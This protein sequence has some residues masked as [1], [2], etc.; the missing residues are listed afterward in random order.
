MKLS[1]VNSS[2]AIH[3]LAGGTS[4]RMGE[5]KSLLRLRGMTLLDW[6]RIT[7]EALGHPVQVI[8][9][10][11]QPGKG[12]LAGIETGLNQSDAMVQLFLSCDMPLVSVPTLFD[13][14]KAGEDSDGVACMEVNERRG[15]P[16]V[17]P[18]RL[19]PFIQSELQAD[20]R[21]L[22][23]LFHHS[24]CKVFR[25][26]TADHMESFNINTPEEFEIARSWVADQDAAAPVTRRSRGLLRI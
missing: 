18:R 15:F 3:I 11:L 4:R 7:A 25:W 13:L 12:P 1:A 16:L 24:E 5:D 8:R 20:R 21:S 17:I 22:Y 6:V 2:V 14:I 19:L 9:R 10:A 26:Q 23:A